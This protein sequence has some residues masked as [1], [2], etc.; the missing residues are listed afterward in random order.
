MNDNSRMITSK[1]IDAPFLF[2]IERTLE[3]IKMEREMKICDDWVASRGRRCGRLAGILGLGLIS[4]LAAGCGRSQAASE[5]SISPE[6]P[7]R[8]I[9]EEVPGYERSRQ[10]VFLGR[11][12][13]PREVEL[14]FELG[15]KLGK[16][17]VG[18]GEWAKE[19]Q[20]IARL[21][22]SK[23][24][25]ELAE[26][27]ERFDF[28]RLNDERMTTLHA[29]GSAPLAEK[30]RAANAFALAR[31]ALERAEDRLADC[32]LRAPFDGRVAN[33]LLEA[34]SFVRPGQSIVVFQQAGLAEI[35]FY[36]T[37]G[38][39]LKL[40]EGLRDGSTSVFLG[41][42]EQPSVRLALQDYAT[43]PDPRSGAYRVTMR[44][45]GELAGTLLP[46]APARVVAQR[47]TA[48]SER[49]VRIPSDALVSGSNGEHRVWVLP[50]AEEPCR[51]IARTV[52]VGGADRTRVEVCGG[53]LPGE[54]VVTAGASMLREDTWVIAR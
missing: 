18:D 1:M 6:G 20:V 36:Q 44:L 33:R 47:T 32:V 5:A 23:I 45:D 52:R 14:A 9:A 37:E 21:E 42:G 28:A 30:E 19:G 26:A 46:G 17:L 54:R 51:P 38:Q 43:A 15:G 13:A 4:A 48:A 3:L 7:R 27:R 40:V 53:L 2:K 8:V 39:L 25:L 49:F 12:R 16:V 11:L 31:L 50:A 29:A 41:I 10:E 24:E 35:D 22:T 34:G